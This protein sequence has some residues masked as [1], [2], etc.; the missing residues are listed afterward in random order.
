MSENIA[1]VRIPA[2]DPLA[3]ELD[4]LARFLLIDRHDRNRFWG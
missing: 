3:D 2:A 1:G 4:Q